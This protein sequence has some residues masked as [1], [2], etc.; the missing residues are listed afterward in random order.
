MFG[1]LSYFPESLC[2]SFDGSKKEMIRCKFIHR[3]LLMGAKKELSEKHC[4]GLDDLI[5]I[6]F[7]FRMKIHFYLILLG[8]AKGTRF[9]TKSCAVCQMR[10]KITS[11]SNFFSFER[12]LEMFGIRIFVFMVTN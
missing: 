2:Q 12:K 4:V 8:D 11:F 3:R 9:F 1:V 5:T 10:T 7:F 6:V